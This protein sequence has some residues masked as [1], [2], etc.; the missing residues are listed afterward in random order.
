MSKRFRLFL[1]IGALVVAGVFL[2]P[3]IQWYFL[4]GEGDRDRAQLTRAEIQQGVSQEAE[5]IIASITLLAQESAAQPLSD[6]QEALAEVVRDRYKENGERLPD[7]I[8]VGDALQ[9]FPT[10]EDF[11]SA[12]EGHLTANF[13]EAKDILS[14][15]ILLGLDLSGGVLVV[16]EPDIASLEERLG[17]SPAEEVVSEALDLALEVINNRIDRFGITEPQIRRRDDNTIEIALPGENDP[18]L[19]NAFLVGKGQ[20]NFHIVD[21]DQSTRIINYAAIQPD[22]GADSEV[23]SDFLPAGLRAL[24]YFSRDYYGVDQYVRHVVVHEN[25]EENGLS[26]SYIRDAQFIRDPLTNQP[27]VNF[28]LDIAGS[29]RFATLTRENVGNSMAIVVDNHVR[30]WAIIQEEIPSGQVRIS[31][32][33]QVEAQNISRVLR[34]AALPVDLEILSQQEVGAQIGEETVRRGLFAMLLG[35]VLVALFILIYY[36]GAGLIAGIML[37]L[38]LILL[39]SILAVFNLT[40]TLASIAGII[41]TV[42][43]AV[44][45]NVIIFERIKEEYKLGKSAH[46]SV[47]A[48]FRKAFL[49]IMDANVTTFIAALFLSQFGSGPIRGFAV[50]LAVGIVTSMFSSLFVSRLVFEFFT[51]VLR[52]PRLSIMWS[53]AP[54]DA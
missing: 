34:T 16:L 26:G 29:N 40:L 54:R 51:E 41:L 38:N 1:V 12:L 18:E 20:L 13:E 50:T 25:I 48:G 22:W 5:S 30:A 27:Q 45:A 28:E 53:P 8:S 39:L 24:P 49:T 9:L 32:F 52:R 47:S 3:S 15:I 6:E 35:F 7:F 37:M 11:T 21:D 23:S 10:Q 43:M 31:G 4:Y 14:R 17:Y 44:D 46:A 33:E 42:G 2:Y 36:R 19:I